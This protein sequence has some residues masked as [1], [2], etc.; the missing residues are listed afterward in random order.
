MF[1]KSD[2]DFQALL[3]DPVKLVERIQGL[4]RTRRWNTI[5]ATVL[6]VYIFG[7]VLWVLSIYRSSVS[8]QTPLGLNTPPGM[9]LLPLVFALLVLQQAVQA[10]I[11]HSELRMLLLFKKLRDDKS[12]VTP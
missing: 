10:V 12:V 5:S 8:H 11:A 3:D 9:V 6:A 2:H 1:E 4:A 7:H